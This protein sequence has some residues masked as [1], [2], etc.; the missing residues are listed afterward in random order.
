MESVDPNPR[1]TANIAE[2]DKTRERFTHR[3]EVQ[4]LYEFSEEDS[5][6]CLQV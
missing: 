4:L 1:L 5:T 2:N 6:L 3:P